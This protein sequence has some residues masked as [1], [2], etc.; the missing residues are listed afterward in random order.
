MAAAVSAAAKATALR[1]ELARLDCDVAA[2][3]ME[4]GHFRRFS[5]CYSY[6]F[7]IVR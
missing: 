7:F 4:I 5:A 2:A 3:E 1:K 6:E